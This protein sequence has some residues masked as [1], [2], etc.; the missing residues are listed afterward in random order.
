MS[1]GPPLVSVGL[2]IYNEEKFLREAL[3][4]LLAQDYPNMELIISDNASTDA[5]QAISLEFA[6]SHPR[7]SYHRNEKNIGATENFNSAFRLSKGEYFMWA[8]G[9]DLWA[10]TYISSCVEVLEGDKTVVVCN[11]QAQIMSADRSVLATFRQIDTRG[12]TLLVRS[13]LLLWHV[14][15]W[16]AYSVFRS[17]ALRQTGLLHRVYAPDNFLGFELSLIGPFAVVYEPLFFMR[18]NRDERARPRNRA[19]YFA[20]LRERLYPKGT[21]SCSRFW[22]LQYMFEQLRAVHR[23]RLS[24]GQRVALMGSVIPAY[25]VWFYQYVPEIMRSRIRGYLNRRSSAPLK[26]C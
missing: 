10:P 14:S 7:V 6:A 17:S 20:E 23:S 12:K 13:N 18:D 1:T 24:L 19:Q 16:V 2:A 9:H 26:Q 11:S 15:A 3:D 5:T 25:F 8:G 21:P 22:R 4:S